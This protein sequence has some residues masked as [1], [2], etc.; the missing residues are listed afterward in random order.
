MLNNI[1]F[2]LKVIIDLISSFDEGLKMFR[3]D[4]RKVVLVSIQ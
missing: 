1:V 4:L 3:M 2:E